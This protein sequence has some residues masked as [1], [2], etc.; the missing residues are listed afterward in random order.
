MSS[1]VPN[2]LPT[3]EDLFADYLELI[4]EGQV[5]DFERFCAAHPARAAAMRKMHV[6]WWA[7]TQAFT[8]LSLGGSA[9]VDAVSASVESLMTK[10]RDGRGR[11]ARYAIGVEIARGAMGRVV[12]AWDG[13]LRRK[14][15]LKIHLDRDGDTRQQRRFLEEAQITGQ[16]DHPGIVPIHE[17]GLDD[18]G[19]PFFAMRLVQ[20]RDLGEVLQKVSAGDDEWTRTRVLHVLLRVCEAMAYAHEKGVVHRDLKP[21][22]IM[23]GRFGET[24]VMDWGLA[25]VA[26]ASGESE[27]QASTARV[28]SLR[29]TIV[30]ED[31]ASPLL[32]QHGDVVGTPAYMAPEL[33]AG[34]A[35]ARVEPS[36]DVYS[37]GAILHHLCAGHMPYVAPGEQI[38]AG[39]V[40]ARVRRGPPPPLQDD[41]PAELRAIV[42]RAIERDPARR[43]VNMAA[44]A[45]DLR[46]YLE[47][48]VVRAYATGGFAEL[49]KW[50]A[51]NRALSVASAIALIALVVGTVVSMRLWQRADATAAR[52]TTELDRSE[53]RNGRLSLGSEDSGS[54]EDGLWRQ[55][56][57]GRM[58]RA[59]AWALADL[60]A[61]SPCLASALPPV[62]GDNPVVFVPGSDEVAIGGG[63]GRIHL[64][65]AA[66]LAPRRIVGEGAGFVLSLAVD[67]D[68]KRAF[69]GNSDGVLTVFE[70]ATGRTLRRMQAHRDLLRAIELAPHGEG[71]ATGGG[72]GRVLWWRDA[73]SEAEEVA[74]HGSP[75]RSLAFDAEGKLLASGDD[76]GLVQVVDLRDHTRKR[77]QL[78]DRSAMALS[79]APQHGALWLGSQMH[80]V[81]VT[82]V[83]AG[84]VLHTIP[85]RNGTCRDLL[86]DDD[87]SVLAGGWWRVDRVSSDGERCTPVALRGVW[88]MDLDRRVRRLVV[89]NRGRGLSLFDLSDRGMRRF[90]GDAVALSSDGRRVALASK[91]STWLR[92]VDGSEAIEP[93]PLVAQSGQL[94]IDAHGERIALLPNGTERLE[95]FDVAT[96]AQLFSC[97]G[98]TNPPLNASFAFSPGG[99][100]LAVVVGLTTVRRLHAHTGAVVGERT[101]AT[102]QVL[103]V[104]FVADGSQLA[105][106]T[107]N[108]QTVFLWSRNDDAL[109]EVKFGFQTGTVAMSSDRR[110][111][112]VGGWQGEIAVRDMVTG[113]VHE[114]R[115]HAGTV[116]SLAFSPVDSGLLV[117]SGGANGV[118]FWDLDTSV[119]CF[120]ALGDTAPVQQVQI[121]A[122]GRTLAA[123]DLRGAVL[124]DLEYHERH[125][126][127]NLAYQLER[128]RGKVEV[129]AA[130]EAEL[131]AW[132]AHVLA[133]PWPRWPSK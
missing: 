7:M 3:A 60:H 88:L 120:S 36:A 91:G 131:R 78:G 63:D 39:E 21:G 6:R 102:G 9:R 79:F 12:S 15:A 103:R 54:A 68:G 49:R 22:N 117:S 61:R 80:R 2:A 109:V 129:N 58:P 105:V 18:D 16:L 133:R 77:L 10:L 42:E 67:R 75:V 110:R 41:V 132:S 71:F 45:N 83:D 90:D 29:D 19:R 97:A 55:H 92:S 95:V 59:T 66:T 94:A 31:S 1:P 85:T 5:V 118:V 128:L 108:S 81:F 44:F 76:Q 17:L 64:H 50:I 124:L 27:P 30:T 34:D 125:V 111:L 82:D 122:D 99:D 65:D 126:A 72:D 53:F 47:L 14:V 130:R 100:E 98:P 57:G 116:W 70:L 123:T 43:Y 115:A 11:A 23:V 56:L 112:A 74:S 86:H 20:G 121:S 51:R 101:F 38:N 8:A 52:L 96:R 48:R 40:L 4:E 104:Q 32:T 26:G 119:A 107:R 114:I 89:T 35:R 28:D 127:G 69:A 84:Q 13:E 93:G 73:A 37:L 62:V 46:A 24:Y 33:A 25:R 113:S 106:I 87:G